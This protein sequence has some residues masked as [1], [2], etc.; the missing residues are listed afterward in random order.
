MAT[1]TARAGLRKPATSDNVDV[2]LDLNNNLD[3]IDDNLG[4]FQCTSGTRPTGSNRF[5]GQLIFETDTTRTLRWDGTTWWI[6][7]QDIWTHT[8]PSWT[9]LTLGNGSHFGKYLQ[10]GKTVWFM[11]RVIFGT[12]S[13]MGAAI[14]LTLPVTP[15]TGLFEGQNVGTFSCIDA[16]GGS[17]SHRGG[18]CQLDSTTE[19][20]FLLAAG[21]VVTT[22]TPFTWANNDEL[23][24]QLMYEVA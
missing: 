22:T 3:K 15:T 9:G 10:L 8:T 4:T 7:A 21:G 11:G 18:F 12:T 6:I 19:A 13:A 24:W 1:S 23:R 16:S 5:V 20:A 17:G 2:V 14:T